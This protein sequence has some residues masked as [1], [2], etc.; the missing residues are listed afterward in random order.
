ME[1]F[2]V[3][4]GRMAETRYS[5]VPGQTRTAMHP[6]AE[7][8]DLEGVDTAPDADPVDDFLGLPRRRADTDPLDL[9]AGRGSPLRGRR[10]AETYQP[11]PG[12]QRSP[13]GE[14]EAYPRPRRRDPDYLFGNDT[15]Y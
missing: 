14:D 3:R 15:R 11:W 12:A 10:E 13:F 7:D 4:D 8:G 6:D 2:R 9:F 5:L 1:H